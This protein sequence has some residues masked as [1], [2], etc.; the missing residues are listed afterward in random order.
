M[1]TA[2]AFSVPTGN[3][4]LAA[5]PRAE[6]ERLNKRKNLSAHGD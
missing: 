6:Y 3:R 1:P 5:L 4:L 2:T